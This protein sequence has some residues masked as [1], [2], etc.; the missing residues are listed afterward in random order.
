MGSEAATFFTSPIRTGFDVFPFTEAGG[1][2]D[3]AFTCEEIIF[4]SSVFS[5]THADRADAIRIPESNDSK[6]CEHGDASVSS[7][8]L[9][10]QGSNRGEDIF[11]ID[12]E[13][14]CLL[15]VVREDVQ[16]ELRVRRCVDVA[17]GTGIHILQKLFGIDK[18]PIL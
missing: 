2:S 6:P 14:A 16:E 7:F 15:K 5:N 18:V 3:D 8:A 1:V 11:L 9:G 10:H 4:A 17:M 13:F 12:T